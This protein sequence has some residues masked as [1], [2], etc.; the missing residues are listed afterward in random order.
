M[1]GRLV[2]THAPCNKPRLR[3]VCCSFQEFPR[4][5]VATVLHHGVL[6]ADNVSHSASAPGCSKNRT[7]GHS[8]ALSRSAEPA[9]PRV[10]QYGTYV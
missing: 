1:Q 10:E 2:S 5:D 6:R 9:H 3:L 8:H 4:A 7:L